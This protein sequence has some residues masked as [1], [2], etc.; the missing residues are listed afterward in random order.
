MLTETVASADVTVTSWLGFG[1]C[2]GC[3]VTVSQE[4]AA[5]LTEEVASAVATV[6]SWLD[7]GRCSGCIGSDS[8]KLWTRAAPLAVTAM[9]GCES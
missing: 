4:A 6:T 3:I 8:R 7:L 2:S 9:S 1:R 5:V